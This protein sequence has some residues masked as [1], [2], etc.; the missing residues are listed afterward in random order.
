MVANL[1][2]GMLLSGSKD[3]ALYDGC[4]VMASFVFDEL[5]NLYYWQTFFSDAPKSNE[6]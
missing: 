4:G 6:K 5:G 2:N 3:D 1:W